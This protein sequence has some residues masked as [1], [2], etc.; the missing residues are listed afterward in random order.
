MVKL[1]A[2]YKVTYGEQVRVEETL[3]LVD[4]LLSLVDLPPG[5]VPPT[6]VSGFT[7]DQLK[8]FIENGNKPIESGA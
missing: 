1:P 3:D 5:Y 8:E 7:A 4:Y 6:D 2:A